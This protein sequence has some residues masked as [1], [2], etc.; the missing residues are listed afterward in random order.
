MKAVMLSAALFVVAGCG[1]GKAD[2]APVVTHSEMAPLST[3]ASCASSR[4][5]DVCADFDDDAGP[6]PAP[7]TP[8]P[9][10]PGGH[11][12]TS[13]KQKRSGSTSLYCQQSSIDYFARGATA[14]KLAFD[15][16]VEPETET[17]NVLSTFEFG[18]VW[19][20]HTK[21]PA[22]PNVA[23]QMVS[24]QVA[25]DK[26]PNGKISFVIND[27]D[28]SSA[29]VNGGGTSFTSNP[30]TIET[31]LVA[32][33]GWHHYEISVTKDA[34]GNLAVDARADGKTVF[35]NQLKFGAPATS[36]FAAEVGTNGYVDNVTVN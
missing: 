6:L 17:A 4:G 25:Y 29:V 9:G 28:P 11:C 8:G 12:T 23:T 21:Q 30:Q 13:T 5:H 1:G 19:T 18:S 33:T 26:S 20:L 32:S 34:A 24:F 31:D 10:A 35:A 2:V 36:G 27:V 22:G 3:I 7:F 14:I 15:A 16:Y